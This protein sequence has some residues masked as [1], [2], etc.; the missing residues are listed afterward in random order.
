MFF[1]EEQKTSKKYKPKVRLADPISEEKIEMYER[2]AANMELTQ[3]VVAGQVEN[4]TISDR[5]MNELLKTW[6]TFI[7]QATSP[8]MHF[9]R[10]ERLVMCYSGNDSILKRFGAN[11]FYYKAWLKYAE[12]TQ[13][14]QEVYEFML[15]KEIGADH[16]S[17]YKHIAKFFEDK[18]KDLK[19]A[20]K[21][22][23][24]G[25]EYL[26]GRSDDNKSI[27]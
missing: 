25:I 23:R 24:K 8:E 20:D 12:K 7:G 5:E 10:V 19:R 9:S 15:E 16:S 6:R 17:L 26:R 2:C 13:N 1:P 11:D 18:E 21:V 4:C 27:K 3:V 22:F 14:C